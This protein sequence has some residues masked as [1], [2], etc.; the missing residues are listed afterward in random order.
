MHAQANRLAGAPAAG[1]CPSGLISTRYALAVCVVCGHEHVHGP[2]RARA[3]C[4]DCGATVHT[5]ALYR[6]RQ[7]RR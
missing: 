2:Q 4:P 1:F 6:D 7:A 3:T 5:F